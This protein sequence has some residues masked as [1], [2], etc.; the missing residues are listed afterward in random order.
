M[1]KNNFF[2]VVKVNYENSRIR[3][4]KKRYTVFLNI[5]VTQIH[6][7]T[8]NRHIFTK[9]YGIYE[10]WQTISYK[11]ARKRLPLSIKNNRQCPIR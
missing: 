8:T 6:I 2:G 5:G 3:N 7:V 9:G 4:T 11:S 10:Y 1:G